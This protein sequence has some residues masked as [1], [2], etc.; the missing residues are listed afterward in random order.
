[1]KRNTPQRKII[2]KALTSQKNH[3]SA[4]LVYEHIHTEYPSISKATVFRVLKQE[5]ADNTVMRIP[6]GDGEARYEIKAPAHYH[7]RCTECGKVIDAPAGL[8]PEL[9]KPECGCE[10]FEILGHNLEFYGICGLCRNRRFVM[11]HH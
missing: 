11:K 2:M 10:D 8:M 9:S 6:C 4:S 3:P 5:A 1:M 7:M